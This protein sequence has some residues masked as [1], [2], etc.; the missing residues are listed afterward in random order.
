LGRQDLYYNTCLPTIPVTLAI[1]SF[2]AVSD[3]IHSD[4]LHA[5][6]SARS[7]LSLRLRIF[8]YKSPHM[9][10]HKRKNTGVSAQTFRRV[11]C[12]AG[13]EPSLRLVSLLVLTL[14]SIYLA[15]LST[16]LRTY[17]DM[18]EKKRQNSVK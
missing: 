17:R 16:S 4:A 3:V 13:T 12:L 9:R 11:Q 14:Q 8:G 10:K 15:Y 7:A 1:A 5:R 2:D 18:K 6:T